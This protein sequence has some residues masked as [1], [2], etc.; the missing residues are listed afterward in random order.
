MKSRKHKKDNQKIYC[1]NPPILYTEITPVNENHKIK[2]N[3][4]AKR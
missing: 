2:T 1:E 3:D 4:F